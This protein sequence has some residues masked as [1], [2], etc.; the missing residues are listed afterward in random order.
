MGKKK[1]PEEKAKRARENRFNDDDY[2][3]DDSIILKEILE[4]TDRVYKEQMDI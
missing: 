2:D 4:Y 3:I 1:T